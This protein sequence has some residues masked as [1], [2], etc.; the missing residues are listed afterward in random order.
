MTEG[1]IKLNI[2]AQARGVYNA[3]LSNGKK[4]YSGRIVFE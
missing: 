2:S 3:V 4:N 1:K